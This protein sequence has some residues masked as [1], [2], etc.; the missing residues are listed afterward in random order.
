MQKRGVL[1]ISCI[2]S[3]NK[4]DWGTLFFFSLNMSIFR[5]LEACISVTGVPGDPNFF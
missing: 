1:K 3:F 5:V 4:I 2:A